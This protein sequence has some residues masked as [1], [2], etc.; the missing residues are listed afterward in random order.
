MRNAILTDDTNGDVFLWHF[1][2][3]LLKTNNFVVI[4]NIIISLFHNWCSA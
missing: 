1:W 2:S 3:N 4:V